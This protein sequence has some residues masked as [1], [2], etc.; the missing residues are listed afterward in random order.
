MPA[1]RQSDAQPAL[2]LGALIKQGRR[3]KRLK[4]ETLASQLNMSQPHLSRIEL[5]R[6]APP[7]D[8]IIVRAAK[9]LDIDPR[10]LLRAAGRQAAG[11]TFE[12]ITLDRLDEI[13]SRLDDLQAAIDSVQTSVARLDDAPPKRGKDKR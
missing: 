1:R 13:T 2:R 7:S 3:R 5:G 4:Q 9:L 11:A 6:H 10:E 8:E 12:E